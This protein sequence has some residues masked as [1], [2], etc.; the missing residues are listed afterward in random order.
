MPRPHMRF[1]QAQGVPNAQTGPYRPE[2]SAEHGVTLVETLIAAFVLM[3]VIFAVFATLDM[4]SSTT[5]VN[6]ART[7]AATIAERDQE[8]MRGMSVT[9]LSNH[10]QSRTV[11]ADGVTYTVESRAEWVR[12]STGGAEGCSSNA[13]QADYIRISSSVSSPVAG[14]TIKPIELR[15]LVAPRVGQFGANQGTL[16]VKVTDEL[17]QPVSGLGV[18]VTG[19]GTYNDSTNEQGC[20]VFSHIPT[21]NY[22]IRMSQAG[23]VDPSGVQAV[24]ATGTVSAGAGQRGAAALRAGRVGHGELR[25]ER[26]RQPRHG[27]VAPADRRQPRRARRR[28]PVLAHR[29]RDVDD[30][31]RALPVPRRLRVLQR[32]VR[33]RRPLALRHGLLHAQPGL[34]A[35]RAPARAASWSTCASRRSTCASPAARTPNSAAP[36]K[37]AYVIIRST[38]GAR[39]RTSSTAC[40]RTGRCPSRACRSARYTICADDRKTGVSVGNRRYAKVGPRRLR[41]SRAGLTPRPSATRSCKPV[42]QSSSVDAGASARDHAPRADVRRC[43]TVVELLV[44]MLVLRH[45]GGRRRRR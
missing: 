20:A 10:H 2:L 35:R 26:R 45:R 4:A 24:A 29:H 27:R 25:H 1:T 22:T 42:D 18:G 17:E 14:R 15:S 6:R 8:R 11:D 30:G 3:G 33:R 43:A 12:D 34:H 5:A 41:T 7:A 21:G 31:G 13:K 38:E 28:A 19:P 40:A 32:R 39:R 44:A 9:Q 23:W 37:D 16:A 36:F